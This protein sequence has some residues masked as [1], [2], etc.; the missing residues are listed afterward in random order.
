MLSNDLKSLEIADLAQV[1]SWARFTIGRP[2]VAVIL[3][4]D[5]EQKHPDRRHLGQ[6]G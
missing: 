4:E 5:A 2:A 6:G 3:L 1:V